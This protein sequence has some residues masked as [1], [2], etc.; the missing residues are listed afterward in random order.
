M[1]HRMGSRAGSWLTVAVLGVVGMSCGDGYRV[2]SIDTSCTQG[3]CEFLGWEDARMM[4]A[5]GDRETGEWH[6]WLDTVRYELLTSGV[7]G[8]S[9][10][11]GDTTTATYTGPRQP[12]TTGYTSEIVLTVAR[13]RD[14]EVR[15]TGELSIPISELA[16]PLLPDPTDETGLWYRVTFPEK[17]AT[18]EISM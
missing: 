17:G 6:S 14:G 11:D 8:W 15:C 5:L 13:W 16:A 18:F 10:C 7:E 12:N 1:V 4:V 3:S 2:R 9:A